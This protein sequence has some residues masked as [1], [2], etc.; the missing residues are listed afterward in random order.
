[1]WMLLSGS[2]HLSSWYCFSVV[3]VGLPSVC[4][5]FF[6]SIA[7]N[8][9]TV[10]SGKCCIMQDNCVALLSLQSS[11][12]LYILA[13][14]RD[15]SMIGRSWIYCQVDEDRTQLQR[16]CL[17]L[18]AAA[19][20]THQQKLCTVSHRVNADP[21][22]E[23]IEALQVTYH[24]LPRLQGLIMAFLLSRLPTQEQIWIHHWII[25]KCSNP[26]R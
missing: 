23:D 10:V 26:Q 8:S 15:V 6:P 18:V 19:D 1:M 22:S 21:P 4:L 20:Q 5:S 24:F 9:M 16:K 25:F 12:C 2:A 11:I 3:F 17:E 13:T 14:W 7:S